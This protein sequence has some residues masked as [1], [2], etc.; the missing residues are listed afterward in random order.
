MKGSK[1]FTKK[2]C[3]TEIK[4]NLCG[5]RVNTFAFNFDDIA[6]FSGSYEG[7]YGDFFWLNH[8]YLFQ[9]KPNCVL[10][11]NYKLFKNT[12]NKDWTRWTKQYLI[13][14]LY[15]ICGTVTNFPVSECCVHFAAFCG[16]LLHPLYSYSVFWFYTPLISFPLLSFYPFLLCPPPSIDPY[17]SIPLHMLLH[18]L[19]SL[20]ALSTWAESQQ[21]GNSSLDWVSYQWKH[22]SFN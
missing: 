5:G 6:W 19:S 3:N 12:S 18:P 20:F 4:L 10:F 1:S 8:N 15:V 16:I 22:K 13:W 21:C 7:F 2:T 17:P 9:T 11:P 14:A